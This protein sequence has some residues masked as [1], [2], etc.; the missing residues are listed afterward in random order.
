MGKHS[1]PTMEDTELPAQGTGKKL[2]CLRNRG[3]YV[4]QQYCPLYCVLAGI[5]RSRKW[6]GIRLKR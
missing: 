1:R 3:H 6:P 2:P 5:V 4:L